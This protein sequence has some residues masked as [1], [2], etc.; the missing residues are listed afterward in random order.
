[1]DYQITINA[2]EVNYMMK[3]LTQKPYD[4]VAMLIEKIDKQVKMQ[5]IKE[6]EKLITDKVKKDK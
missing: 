4:E 2:N 5:N 6:Q 1:M 3:A